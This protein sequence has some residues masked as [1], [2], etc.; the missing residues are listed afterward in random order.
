MFYCTNC[1]YSHNILLNI[2]S[3]NTGIHAILAEGRMLLA[4]L[5]K[6]G[7]TENQ[8]TMAR[9]NV[10]ANCHYER[11]KILQ[12]TSDIELKLYVALFTVQHDV[13]SCVSA[14]VLKWIV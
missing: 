3:I 6:T 4:V 5:L 11:H 12:L 7:E 8:Q 2:A 13:T 9:F 1:T 14:E 10:P